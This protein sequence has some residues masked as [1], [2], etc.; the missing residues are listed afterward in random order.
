MDREDRGRWF[1]LGIVIAMI[2]VPLHV[3]MECADTQRQKIE[4][5]MQERD[6]ENA[7]Q[8]PPAPAP[9]KSAP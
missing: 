9:R 6:R 8:T 5:Q 4:R 3:L 7:P 2:I 1:R